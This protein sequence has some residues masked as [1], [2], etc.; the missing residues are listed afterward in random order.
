MSTAPI[1]HHSDNTP[2]STTVS[3]AVWTARRVHDSTGREMRVDLYRNGDLAGILSLLDARRP[4]LAT[5]ALLAQLN[6]QEATA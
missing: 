4:H 3:G 6:A 5:S 2:A 1:R